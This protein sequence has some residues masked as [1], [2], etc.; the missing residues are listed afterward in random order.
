MNANNMSSLG[1]EYS[2][3]P[4]TLGTTLTAETYEGTGIDTQGY[5]ALTFLIVL[6]ALVDVTSYA[7]HLEDSADD[8]TYADVASDYFIGSDDILTVATAD[9]LKLRKVGYIGSKRYVRAYLTVTTG[10]SGSL[11]HTVIAVLGSPRQA[12]VASS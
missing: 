5:E 2:I 11:P 1:F 7:V 3:S 4:V 12:P 9:T 10:G 6:G 8:V